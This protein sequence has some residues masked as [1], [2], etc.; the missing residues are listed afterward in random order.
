MPYM[1]ISQEDVLEDDTVAEPLDEAAMEYVGTW[2]AKGMN[3]VSSPVLELGADGRGQFNSSADGFFTTFTWKY[4]VSED[5]DRCDG[6][7]LVHY[8]SVDSPDVSFSVEDGEIDVNVFGAY[9]RVE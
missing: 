6:Y 3:K 5:G 1:R 9:E 4:V 8:V 7:I 2:W